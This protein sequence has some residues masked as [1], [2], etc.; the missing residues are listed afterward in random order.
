MLRFK[1]MASDKSIQR[2]GPSK[3]PEYA[4]QAALTLLTAKSVP[5][6]IFPQPPIQLPYS[7]EIDAGFYIAAAALSHPMICGSMDLSLSRYVPRHAR[8][9]LA[10]S[11]DK[12]TSP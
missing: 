1:R 8:I 2:G 7:F 11:V 6:H 3:S 9:Y 4:S 10:L 12:E 5:A